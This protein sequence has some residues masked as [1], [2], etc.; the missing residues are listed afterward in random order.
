MNY[1]HFWILS[2][3]ISASVWIMERWLYPQNLFQNKRFTQ[4]RLEFLAL[5]YNTQSQPALRVRRHWD[6]GTSC[7]EGSFTVPPARNRS[8]SL[9]TLNTYRPSLEKRPVAPWGVGQ[10]VE[11]SFQMTAWK[12]MQ[13]HSF[14]RAICLNTEITFTW[15][16]SLH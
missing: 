16:H 8:F 1:V 5:L 6:V 3:A 14:L 12:C 10:S 2:C 13:L 9:L 7:D 11:A 15:K 4:T